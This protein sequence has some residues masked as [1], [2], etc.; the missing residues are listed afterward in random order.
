MDEYDRL[1]SLLRLADKIGLEVSLN[2]GDYRRFDVGYTNADLLNVITEAVETAR[3]TAGF[4]D[5]LK[6][7]TAAW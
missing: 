6:A 3:I 5:E 4:A 1:A 2:G 7:V